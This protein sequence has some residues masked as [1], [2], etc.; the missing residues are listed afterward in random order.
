MPQAHVF[1]ITISKNISIFSKATTVQTEL[2]EQYVFIAIISISVRPFTTI[3]VETSV[4][5]VYPYYK[6][7]NMIVIRFLQRRNPASKSIK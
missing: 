7:V 2:R 4:A 6:T 5:K 1:N 3:A